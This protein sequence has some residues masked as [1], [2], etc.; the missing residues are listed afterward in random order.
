MRFGALGAA[1]AVAVVMSGNRFYA[2]MFTF[3]LICLTANAEGSPQKNKGSLKN[4][5]ALAKARAAKAWKS[6]KYALKETI[7]S[8]LAA[9]KPAK[10]GSPLPEDGA[11]RVFIH[12]GGG[13]V[14]FEQKDGST[15]FSKMGDLSIVRETVRSN[16]DAV[17]YKLDFSER[18]IERADGKR[19]NVS[20]LIIRP[21]A[22]ELRFRDLE[23]RTAPDG[24]IRLRNTEI[25]TATKNNR[26]AILRAVQPLGQEMYDAVE[27]ALE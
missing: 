19:T 13:E 16:I 27:R 18:A 7:G 10:N 24:A 21:P 25:P 15:V 11:K 6:P 2:V 12:I 20:T 9:V 3:A 4:G 14:S 5:F 8:H 22:R 26:A 17:G 1:L 23:F